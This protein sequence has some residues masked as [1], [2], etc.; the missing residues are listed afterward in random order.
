MS[1][2]PAPQTEVPSFLAGT[3]E[4]AGLIR[5][6]DWTSTPLGGFDTWR[7]SLKAMVRMLL[8]TQHPVFIFWGAEHI[9]LY[10]DAYSASLGPEKHPTILGSRGRDAWPEIWSIIGPQIDMVLRGKGSTWNENQ[11]VPIFRHGALQDVYWTYS[12]GPIDDEQ[13]PTGVGGVL[14]LCT[15]TTQQVLSQHQV[16]LERERFSELFEQA[17]T[18]M[19]VLRGPDHVFEL[20][21]PSYKRLVGHRPVLGFTVAEALPEAVAQGYLALLDQVF[22][23]GKAVSV[24]GAKYAA[25]LEEGGPVENRYLDFVY[26][27]ITNT[28]GQVTG[29]FVEGVDVTDLRVTEQ[30]LSLS[31][32][33]FRMAVESSSLGTFDANLSLNQLVLSERAQDLMGLHGTALTL[34]EGFDRVH[35]DD[36]DALHRAIEQARLTDGRYRMRH[37]VISPGGQVRWLSVSGSLKWDAPLEAGGVERL[38]G[39]MWDIT[40]QQQLLEAL[41]S[42]D[43]RK[44]EFLA[45]LAH[46]LRNPLAPIRTAA[47][48]LSKA[49]LAHDRIVWC[50]EVIQRQART[51]ALLLDDLLDVARITSGKLQLKKALVSIGAVV[52]AAL[53]TARPLIDAKRHALDVYMADGSVVFE[54]DPLRIAQVLTNLLTNAAKYTAPG[55]RIQLNIDASAT[56]IRFEV[57]DTGLG[58]AP[59]MLSS[60]FEMFQQVKGTLDSAEGGLGIGLAL[61][62][63]LIELHGGQIEAFSAGLGQGATFRIVLPTGAAA[64]SVPTIEQGPAS[65]SGSGRRILVADDNKDGAESLAMYLDMMGYEVHVAHDGLHA[66]DLAG[67]IKPDV[68]VLDIGMPGLTG[69]EV[70]AR[71]RSQAW[72]TGMVLIATTGWGQDED[73]RR[74]AQAGFDAH[75]TKPIDPDSVLALIEQH[76]ADRRAALGP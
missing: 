52:D 13:A 61:S 14:V 60:I 22:R 51:M 42:A 20:A 28:N 53:E 40:E 47:H 24:K 62:R 5:A 44:D 30:A 1:L 2:S 35:P 3:G 12:Y 9:C 59:E 16:T 72:A 70:A 39:V 43:R 41:Q 75:V 23:D 27:P 63:G 4:M 56:S 18:F 15:E 6:F 46:E 68:A 58:F 29:I 55:G 17:P 64:S 32:E 76:Q 73:K 11:L 69:Y 66:L 65:G 7:P 26:Q 74:A 37:R 25:Q 8:T 33:R 54:A 34:Q 31:E 48:L 10:N 49:D 71:L 38:V 21:N 19:A 45:V 50:G 67:R 57:V 36:I